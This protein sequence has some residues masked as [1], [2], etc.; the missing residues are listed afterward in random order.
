MARKTV[1]VVV[2]VF[3]L[4]TIFISETFSGIVLCN[5]CVLLGNALFLPWAPSNSVQCYL[6]ECCDFFDCQLLVFSFLPAIA[7]YFFVVNA[8]GCCFCVLSSVPCASRLYALGEIQLK[9]NQVHSFRPQY[10]G[11]R[12]A[13][14]MA[15]VSQSSSPQTVIASS[16]MQLSGLL[17]QT[18]F[19][20]SSP[21]TFMDSRPSFLPGV[22]ASSS[23]FYQLSPLCDCCT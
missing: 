15:C 13:T 9:S 1:V 20:I 5:C 21:W 17:S 18:A 12:G 22:R 8:Q 14:C 16:T 6:Q 11:W 7:H 23:I 4:S 3:C 2:S 19:S 10:A